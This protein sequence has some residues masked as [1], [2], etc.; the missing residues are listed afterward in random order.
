MGELAVEREILAR[1]RDGEGAAFAEV[2]HAYTGLVR[3]VARGFFRDAFRQEEAIQ[4]VWLLAYQK[5]EHLDLERLSEFEGWL[6]VLARRRC[7]DLVRQEARTHGREAPAEPDALEGEAP[8]AADQDWQLARRELQAAVGEF[9]ARLKPAWRAFFALCFVQGRD[10]AEAGRELGFGRVRS[11]YLKRAL[12]ARAR[13]SPRL[14]R[15]LG[16]DEEG[17]Q[18][19]V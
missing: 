14:R 12:A 2:L 16:L 10:A 1:F 15:A 3:H 4:E 9:Q 11:K 19:H 5:R 7:I 8:V 6:R 17:G 13:R 18:G